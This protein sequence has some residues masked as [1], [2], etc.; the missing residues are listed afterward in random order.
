MT[1][2]FRRLLR[3]VEG[4]GPSP[5]FRE[6]LRAQIVAET[7]DIASGDEDVVVLDLTSSDSAP[8]AS[9]AK[10]RF[11][12]LVACAAAVMAI[13]GIWVS[14]ATNDEPPVDVTT[15]LVAPALRRRIAA[16][17]PD[18]PIRTPRERIAL[19]DTSGDLPVRQ[20]YF[21]SGCPHNRSTVVPDGSA[22]GRGCS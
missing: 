14:L 2:D 16:V 8:A 22:T 7:E 11:G 12:L 19:I 1:G 15:D 17:L 18:A 10:P 6:Q 20:P 21:C 9:T 3:G 13:A 5:A 4:E